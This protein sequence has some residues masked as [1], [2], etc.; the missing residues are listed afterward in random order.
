MD[1]LSFLSQLSIRLTI[2]LSRLNHRYHDLCLD[3]L[4][5][6]TV[7]DYLLEFTKIQKIV[8]EG[9]LHQTLNIDYLYDNYDMIY[10]IHTQRYHLKIE[11]HCFS[12]KN[13]NIVMKNNLDFKTLFNTSFNPISNINIKQVSTRF[14]MYNTF[15]I[16]HY[17]I[18]K[19][20]KSFF[21]DYTILLYGN[22]KPEK[23]LKYNYTNQLQSKFE[24]ISYQYYSKIYIYIDKYKITFLCKGNNYMSVWIDYK[25]I[26]NFIKDALYYNNMYCLSNGKNVKYFRH[27]MEKERFNYFIK[28]YLGKYLKCLA[29]NDLLFDQFI[30]HPKVKLNKYCK[31]IK[32]K[33][34]Y[35]FWLIA[36]TCCPI[37][38]D[39]M[40]DIC[41]LYR[42]LI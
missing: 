4:S 40:I 27:Y 2:I 17:T 26:T 22:D 21:T 31:Y 8:Y 14:S 7:H 24:L 15:L 23:I 16:D 18:Y 19:F 6:K 25:F 39:N 41:K 5:L 32:D 1:N 33:L 30:L 10:N 28:G 9:A 35:R 3:L 38:N 34:L 13:N 12:I 11:N 20:I 42:Q 29:Q 37:V 36:Q